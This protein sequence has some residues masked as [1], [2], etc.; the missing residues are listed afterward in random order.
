[1]EVTSS[2]VGDGAGDVDGRVKSQS[3]NLETMALAKKHKHPRDCRITF[4]EHGH[5]YWLDGAVRFPISISGVYETF[6]ER[7]DA[8]AIVDKY[9][10]QWSTNVMSKYYFH[11]AA[12]TEAG[13]NTSAIKQTI[14][15]GWTDNAAIASGRG[16]YIHRQIEL[17]LNGVPY[18]NGY[19]E[20]QQ[21]KQFMVE[22][23]EL[24]GWVP[25]RTEWAIYDV[26]R[27][28][29]GQ[30]DAVFY[31]PVKREYHMVDWKTCRDPLDPDSGA[32]YGRRGRAPLDFL[33][34]NKFSKYAA[35]QNLYEVL[36]SDNY[37]IAVKS[38]WLVQF[39]E[40]QETYIL[41][42]V[43]RFQIAARQMLDQCACTTSL[44][45]QR[46]EPGC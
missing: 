39:H 32:H 1:M 25:Y 40:V 26:E 34:D 42:S 5:T 21:F 43:P 14:I 23:V 28:I 8:V 22:V 36:L 38:M 6:F 19:V 30:I 31:D 27:M 15:D 18:D 41:H 12:R 45:P 2:V 33:V 13:L 9:F 35:Q 3:C 20:M 46:G 16:T 4:V 10:N 11:I 17:A 29:A 24:R 7:F 37:N 44:A